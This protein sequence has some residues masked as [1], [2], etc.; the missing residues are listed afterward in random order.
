[1]TDITTKLRSALGESAF[2]GLAVVITASECKEAA[3]EIDR[4]RAEVAGKD[5]Q[6]ADLRNKAIAFAEAL[7]LVL[8]GEQDHD[9][10]PGPTGM[11]QEQCDHVIAARSLALKFL[12]D[13]K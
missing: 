3:D 12:K 11:T 5:A 9:I 4:L 13:G 10:D 7:D 2:G 6:I 8:D 1:M